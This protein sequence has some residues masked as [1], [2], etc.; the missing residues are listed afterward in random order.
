M[1]QS[2][3]IYSQQNDNFVSRR[4]QKTNRKIDKAAILYH[5][6][7][8]KKRQSL[9]TFGIQSV[10]QELSTIYAHF[11]VGEK[12]VMVSNTESTKKSITMVFKA[13]FICGIQNKQAVLIN[14][15]CDVMQFGLEHTFS[16]QYIHSLLQIWQQQVL[17]I[18]C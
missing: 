8:L 18:Y 11:Y 7:V 10:I 6:E 2:E 9:D 15:G 3:T 5:Q 12:K 1:V 4:L 16:G 17:P 13:K 14:P